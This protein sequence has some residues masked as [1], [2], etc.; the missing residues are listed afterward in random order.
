M[1]KF[2]YDIRSR[3]KDQRKDQKRNQKLGQTQKSFVKLVSWQRNKNPKP[4]HK[5]FKDK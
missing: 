3:G 4:C 5:F 1:P 2:V